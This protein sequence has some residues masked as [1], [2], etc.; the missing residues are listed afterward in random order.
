MDEGQSH[1]LEAVPPYVA[2]SPVVLSSQAAE[3]PGDAV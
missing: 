1:Q 3:G 2:G